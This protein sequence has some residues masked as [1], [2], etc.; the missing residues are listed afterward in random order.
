MT[1]I[2]IADRYPSL[3][4]VTVPDALPLIRQRGL[5]SAEALLDMYEV[6]EPTRTELLETRRPQRVDIIHEDYGIA[7]LSDHRPLSLA[8]LRSCLDDG[9][10]PAQWLRM[11]NSKVFFWVD[12]KRADRLVEAAGAR[13][14]KRLILTFDTLSILRAH[15]DTVSICPINSGATIHRAARRGLR[16]FAR[17]ADYSWTAWSTLRGLKKPDR[18][19]EVTIDRAV[20]GA[21]GYLRATS[22]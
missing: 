5:L 18:I 10:D 3:F 14:R 1:P 9:I 17:P 22:A 4:H 7:S 13:S 12:R 19:V 2:E 21:L 11:L 15:F 20:P 6:K 16:T 8:K